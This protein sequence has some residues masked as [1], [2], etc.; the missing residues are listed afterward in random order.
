M[1]DVRL[2]APVDL[3]FQSFWSPVAGKVSAISAAPADLPAGL[4]I[5]ARYKGLKPPPF[6][7]IDIRLEN[8][9]KLRIG[10]SGESKLMVRRESLG[11][12]IGETVWD[13][14][15]RRAW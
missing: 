4:P 12:K 9:G 14:V 15:A 13:F 6:Y 5:D 1:R 11:R 7:V 2:N 8:P 3:L 10:M